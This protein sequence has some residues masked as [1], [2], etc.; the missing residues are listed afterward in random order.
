MRKTSM[1][2]DIKEYGVYSLSGKF[3][4]EIKDITCYNHYTH[5]LHHYIKNQHYIKNP[6]WYIQRKIKQRLIFMP[7]KMHNRLHSGISDEHF[8]TIYG[9]ERKELLF[10][11]KYSEY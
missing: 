3:M 11:K 2:D 9:I 1:D 10:S 7:K 8:K 5:N 6:Q 4:P